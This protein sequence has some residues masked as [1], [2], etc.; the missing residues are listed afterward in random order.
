VC[1]CVCVYRYSFNSTRAA[2]QPPR[3]AIR[4]G[5]RL[6]DSKKTLKSQIDLSDDDDC[7]DLS[8]LVLLEKLSKDSHR[9]V[10]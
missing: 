8:V 7:F 10:T 6:S 9:F 4:Q 2:V 5:K 1:V 3:V